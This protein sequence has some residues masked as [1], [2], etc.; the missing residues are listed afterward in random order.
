MGKVLPYESMAAGATPPLFPLELEM[1]GCATQEEMNGNVDATLK[2]GYQSIIPYLTKSDGDCSI[3]GSGPS[4]EETASE[5]CG[6]VLAIN[7]A[8][9]Y[10]LGR[11]IV[12]KWAMIW[13]ADMICREFAVPHPDV[14][15]LI[16]ARC[17]PAVFD[18]LR[19]CKVVTWF[20]GGD[21]NIAEYM[22]EKELDDPL[23]NGGSAGVT[24]ALYLATALGYKHLHVFGADSS[25]SEDGRTH[26]HKSLVPEKDFTIFVGNGQGKRP[27]RTTPEWCAQVNEFRDIYA[28]F[29][30]PSMKGLDITVYGD[31]MLPHMW[32][33]MKAKHEAGKIWNADGTVHASF[34]FEKAKEATKHLHTQPLEAQNAN[35]G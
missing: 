4:I 3:V 7:Q 5:L 1:V 31:G 28:M 30:H 11:G 12:P 27:F 20:A 9:G 32:R 33:I 10:L 22:V 26:V 35:A 6:D 24:R 16:A 25:Y 18:R 17:H 21:H 13:D 15:Y 14:T 19:G 23:V 2:R 34:N 29:K 8:I